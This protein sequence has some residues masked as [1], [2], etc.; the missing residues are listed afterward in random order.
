VRRAAWL[1]EPGAAR[2]ERQAVLLSLREA[3]AE[4]AVIARLRA[5][6]RAD[7]RELEARAVQWATMEA[8]LAIGR[9]KQR[10]A[11]RA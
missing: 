11:A 6:W 8:E 3:A 4:A 2:G 7:M 1:P 5:A 9:Y 10:K